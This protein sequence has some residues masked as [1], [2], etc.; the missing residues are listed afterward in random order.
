MAF[1]NALQLLILTGLQSALAQIY[2]NGPFQLRISS[3]FNASIS[4]KQY[5]KK[6]PLPKTLT[7]TMHI[8]AT[9]TPAP[10][11][12]TSASSPATHER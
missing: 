8:Q 3:L 5:P 6:A 11:A 9:H 12:Q 2:A 10:T 7:L 4:G 1:R